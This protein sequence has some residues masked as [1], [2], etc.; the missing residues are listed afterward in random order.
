[1][2]HTAYILLGSNLE[3]PL[4]QLERAILKVQELEHVEVTE[5]SSIYRSEPWRMGDVPDFMNQVI[6]VKCGFTASQ[7]LDGLLHIEQHMGRTRTDEKGYSSRIIDLDIL[8]F[9]ELIYDEDGLTIPHPRIEE[10]KFVLAPLAE[11]IPE[12]K[13]PV[14]GKTQNALLSACEDSSYIQRISK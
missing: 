14:N 2:T 9:G 4:E 7:L 5:T 10:R 12:F 3:A 6:E 1:M 8:Y 13:H 11:L